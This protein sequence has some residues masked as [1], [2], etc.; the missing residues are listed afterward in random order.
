MLQEHLINILALILGKRTLTSSKRRQKVGA[1]ITYI[2]FF[3]CLQTKNEKTPTINMDMNTSQP[4]DSLR[5]KLKKIK[6]R[7]KVE[8]ERSKNGDSIVAPAP[9]PPLGS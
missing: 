2:Y 5:K 7:K 6:K 9:F 4:Q 1:G 8:K 3:H